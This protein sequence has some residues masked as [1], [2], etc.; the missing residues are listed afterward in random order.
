M[1]IIDNIIRSFIVFEGVRPFFV[2]IAII[3]LNASNRPAKLIILTM[4]GLFCSLESY[5]R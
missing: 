5:R 3:T 4:S 1:N 2:R